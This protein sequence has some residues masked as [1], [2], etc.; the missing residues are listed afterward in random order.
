MATE[1]SV[2]SVYGIP[3]LSLEDEDRLRRQ[4]N[5]EV[6][7]YFRKLLEAE[8]INPDSDLKNDY[9]GEHRHNWVKKIAILDIDANGREALI[10]YFEELF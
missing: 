9:D 5:G 2:I 8:K 6:Y 3:P 10:N 1:S 7:A 4:R